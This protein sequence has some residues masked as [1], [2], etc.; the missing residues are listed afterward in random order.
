MGM[1]PSFGKQAVTNP[2]LRAIARMTNPDLSPDD[3]TY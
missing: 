2:I 1:V 3:D